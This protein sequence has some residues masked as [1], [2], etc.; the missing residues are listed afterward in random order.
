MNAFLLIRH[1]S[2]LFTSVQ[3]NRPQYALNHLKLATR[4][5]LLQ[6]NLPKFVRCSKL[7][8]GILS[9]REVLSLVLLYRSIRVPNG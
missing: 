9:F 4:L 5:S 7:T 2:D 8:T 1:G 6:A 3:H